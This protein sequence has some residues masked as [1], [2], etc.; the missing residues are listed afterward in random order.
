MTAVVLRTA[1]KDMHYSVTPQYQC[2][3]LVNMVL[4]PLN[5]MNIGLIGLIMKVNSGSCGSVSQLVS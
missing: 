2:Q 5:F 1:M 4:N 3:V